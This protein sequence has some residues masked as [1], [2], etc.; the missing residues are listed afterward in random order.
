MIYTRTRPLGLTLL[1]FGL[2]VAALI[3]CGPSAPYND[4]EGRLSGVTAAPQAEDATAT[5]D[6]T[7]T[8]EPTRTPMPT[9][10]LTFPDGTEGCFTRP[11]PLPDRY[12]SLGMGLHQY[13]IDYEEAEAERVK[14]EE[15]TGVAE[16]RTAEE[17]VGVVIHLEVREE[18]EEIEQWL[19]DNGYGFS[20]NLKYEGITTSIHPSRIIEAR[21]VPGVAGISLPRPI[22]GPA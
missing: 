2:A 19:R 13:V 21:D 5:P 22:G 1:L 17:G 4:A 18:S 11:T 16:Q 20:N 6:P 15:E 7:D 12:N 9:V 14:Q 10:C 3:A 8:P